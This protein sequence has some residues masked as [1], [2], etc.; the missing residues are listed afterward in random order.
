MKKIVALV[1]SLVMVLGLATTAFGAITLWGENS[2]TVKC[3]IYDGE[4]NT[5]LNEDYVEVGYFP[6]Q[7]LKYEK[8]GSVKQVGVIPHY[9][10]IE[11]D[12]DGDT[13]YYT[14]VRVDKIPADADAS[15]YFM[16]KAHNPED[17]VG[18]EWEPAQT[19]KDA[20]YIMKLVEEVVYIVKAEAFT[21]WSADCE[22]YPTPLDADEV[23]YY[24]AAN[25][26]VE[27][28]VPFITPAVKYA[29]ADEDSEDVVPALVGKE[30]VLLDLDK[31]VE[32]TKHAWVASA[33]DEDGVT[34]K[35]TCNNC[36]TVGTV[37]N[38]SINAPAGAKI[39]KLVD[40]T[41]IA[42]HFPAVEAPAG[43]KVES[44]QTFDA[45]IAM[46]VGMSVMAAAGSAVVLK[47]KD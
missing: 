5:K 47:K 29:E 36:K 27:N 40:G 23:D 24:T 41:L 33:W 10:I 44:A 17:L 37:I 3:D 8:D 32:A 31:Y 1:L 19:G 35:Y 6:G 43:D 20:Y 2:E 21:A 9:F 46:Y 30:V 26:V 12:E 7:A 39:D 18:Y 14:F 25:A 38:A 45:G 34:T 13:Y 16:V 15:K 22:A 42:Y 28:G 4:Y 11:E